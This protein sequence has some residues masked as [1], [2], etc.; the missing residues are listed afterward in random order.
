MVSVSLAATEECSNCPFFPFLYVNRERLPQITCIVDM[1][2]L[3]N[4][5][6]LPKCPLPFPPKKFRFL[7]IIALQ[8]DSF[9]VNV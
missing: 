1:F 8:R 9:P 4:M 6:R 7:R 5:V 2:Y 3:Q